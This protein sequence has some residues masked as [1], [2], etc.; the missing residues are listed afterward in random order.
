ML[1]IGALAALALGA[2]ARARPTPGERVAAYLHAR[3]EAL[4]VAP[5]PVVATYID[6]RDITWLHPEK[7]VLA[8]VAN[9]FNVVILA[10]DL[11]TGPTDMLQGW[12][13]LDAATRNAT[14]AAAHAAGAVL[15]LSA[16]GASEE[17]YNRVGGAAYGAAV[18]ATAAALGLD[19]A[20]FDL[21]N[22]AP[23]FNFDP[24][25]GDELVD[26]FVNATRAAR[27][28]MGP[29]AI[30]THAP[31]APYFG[32][33]GDAGS[34][35]GAS[36]GYTAIW[37]AASD[38]IDFFNVQFYNQGSCYT[39]YASLFASSEADAC[40]FPKTSVAELVAMGVDARAIVVGKPLFDADADTG[41]VDGPTLAA[42]LRQARNESGFATGAFCWSWAADGGA[43]WAA[44][45]GA[46]MS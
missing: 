8:A 12:A 3:G 38:A 44:E 30:L 32:T 2:P 22:L 42:W 7:T 27:A 34:W 43:A 11:A 14:L 33:I 35:V 19:G 46:A 24:L 28:A 29:A 4:A 25:K 16:G 31:Q 17:P 40:V 41:Y 39:S 18:G 6:W 15:L 10:F 26:W 5:R 1:R 13:S 37:R 36:G 23:G 45:V 21:E 20:D 9:G